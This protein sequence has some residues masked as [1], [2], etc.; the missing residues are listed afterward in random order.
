MALGIYCSGGFGREKYDLA[1]LINIK[2]YHWSDI[3]FID[4]VSEAENANGGIIYRYEVFKQK[5]PPG[6]AKITIAIG[7]PKYR[8]TMADKVI[9]DGYSLQSLIHPDV[10]IGTGTTIGD[11]TIIAYYPYISC[12]N[13]KYPVQCHLLGMCRLL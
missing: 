7:E 3:V 10:K 12:K 5:F 9:S 8:R 4:D 6:N 13:T 1:H 11:G 2:Y